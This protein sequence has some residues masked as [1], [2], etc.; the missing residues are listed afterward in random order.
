[1][2]IRNA[3]SINDT[4]VVR[5]YQKNSAKPD[6]SHIPGNCGFPVIGNAHNMLFNFES[7]TKRSYEKYGTIFKFKSM[8]T[9]GTEGVWLLGP[10]GN[11]LVLQ[12]EGNKF[13]NFYGWNIAFNGLFDN[14]ILEQDF[15]HHKSN[16]KLLQ[17]AFKKEAIQSHID[18]MGPLIKSG[19][20]KWPKGKLFKTMGPLKTLLLNTGSKVFLGVEPGRDSD[21]INQA[22]V[23]II[24][25]IADPFK[26]RGP[27]FMPYAK[28]V[29][30]RATISKF[31]FDNI[32]NR[33]KNPGRDLF[34]QLC[35]LSDD[36]GKKF[37][38]EDVR[39]QILFLLFAAH[40][41]TTSTLC[42]LLHAIGSNQQ[43]QDELREEVLGLNK[44]S[45]DFDDFTSMEKAGWT[46]KETLRMYPPLGA[47]PRYTIEDVEFNGYT[48]PANSQV[49]ISAIFTHYME[50]YW[51]NPQT[52]D[53]RRFSPERAE[54]KKDFFQYVPFG[55]GA[56]KC[57]GMHFAEVQVKTFLF[58][59]LKDYRV[60]T[61]RPGAEYKFRWIPLTFPSD[62]LPLKFTK[63]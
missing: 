21:K 18:I 5:D 46:I 53:P 25:G 52:F 11:R 14:A 54:D 44:E 26:E 32:E 57:L 9:I 40:D 55:G 15:S 1:M 2:D 36:D 7:Y 43:W 49:M 28:G 31:I 27:F 45:L 56:H 60:S 51:T 3:L 47:F 8:A 30:G 41:T 4:S 63:L 61:K 19:I 38:D 58:H 35:L 37:S 23:D 50:E 10:E 16:R 29:K 17:A 12:N 62:G 48:I 13:S 22:F 39:D 59:L 33:R 42:S 6:L 20:S 24:H 34:S